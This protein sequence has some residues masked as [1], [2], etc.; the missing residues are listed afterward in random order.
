MD[1]TGNYFSFILKLKLYENA[2]NANFV[3]FENT[4]MLCN[5]YCDA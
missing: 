4:P 2:N 5:Y 3:Y 1:V